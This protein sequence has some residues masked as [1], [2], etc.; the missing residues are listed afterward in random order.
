MF[1][2]SCTVLRS[3]SVP[4]PVQ[5]YTVL[6][7]VSVPSPVQWYTVLRTVS[8]P[9]PVQWYTVLRTVSVPSPVQWYIYSS[10]NITISHIFPC[11]VVPA[12][13]SLSRC[14]PLYIVFA[15]LHRPVALNATETGVGVILGHIM[16]STPWQS[17]G[18]PFLKS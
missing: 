13:Q 11:S 1:N 3:V 4:S 10:E 7:T 2:G 5:W 12:Y 18:S 17:T 6:R 9:S 8:V 15:Y 16:K 14:W